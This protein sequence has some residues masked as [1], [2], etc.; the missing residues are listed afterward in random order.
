MNEKCQG[1]VITMTL[2]KCINLTSKLIKATYNNM[3]TKLKLDNDPLQS[4]VY[5][6]NF[7]NSFKNNPI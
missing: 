2:L 1:K 5:F 7:M 3:V 4:R 6:L